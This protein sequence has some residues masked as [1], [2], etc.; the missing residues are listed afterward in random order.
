MRELPR[1]V[2]CCNKLETAFRDFI[3][4]AFVSLQ[5]YGAVEGLQASILESC[6]QMLHVYIKH[7]SCKAYSLGYRQ[8][9]K[10]R[11]SAVMIAE[12]AR[13]GDYRSILPYVLAECT[14]VLCAC[15]TVIFQQ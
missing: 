2:R 8:W 14:A 5:R 15:L 3:F 11:K 9:R 1:F 7:H 10:E 6:R 12:M 13:Q 4:C